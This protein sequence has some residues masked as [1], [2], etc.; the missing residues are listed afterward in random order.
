MDII[1]ILGIVCIIG[2]GS[3]FLG[4]GIGHTAGYRTGHRDGKRE[5]TRLTLNAAYGKYANRAELKAA[6]E[7]H[8][9]QIGL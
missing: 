2:G 7:E 1:T 3:L 4:A 9:E 6:I 8:N 5:G